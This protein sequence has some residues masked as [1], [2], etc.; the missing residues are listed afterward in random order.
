MLICLHNN[1]VHKMYLTHTNPN[2][3]ARQEA[4]IQIAK[5]NYAQGKKSR[6]Q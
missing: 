3:L 6:Y 4:N 1:I 2:K 5:P